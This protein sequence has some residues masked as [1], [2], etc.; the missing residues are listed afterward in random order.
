MA[1]T[2]SELKF[3]LI[4]TGEQAGTWGITTD[5]NIGTAI[6]EAIT[7][8]ADV[9][10]SSAADVTVTLTDTNATQTARNLRLNLTESGAGIGYTGNLV[11]GSGCQIEK[12]YIIN[13]GTTATKTV[14]NTT[15]TGI[16]VP[17]GKTMLV[18]NNGTNVVDVTTYLSSVTLGTDLAVADG[19]TGASTFSSGALLKGAGTSPITTATA[20]TDYVAPAT[21]TTF[22]ATQ[23]FNG[24]TA[25]AAIKTNNIDELAS[26]TA[27]APAS[28]QTFYVNT[29][30]VQ[31]YTNNAAN[32]W[33][34]NFA[35]SSGTSLNTAMATGDSIS[36]TMLTTQSATAYYNSAVQVDGNSVTPKWQGGS[37]PT[38]GNA[39]SIDSYTYV[40]IKTGSAAFTVLA[41][42]TKFA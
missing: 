27:S 41:A 37:A 5:T 20:G 26:I 31:Y 13:N 21:A 18:F 36:V 10:Y 24:S 32:N 1:S 15:G 33:T 34:V 30:A 19:G 23:T 11:L 29:G 14:K 40:I 9:A 35:F 16:A 8:S 3:E 17:A 2:Y 25:T 28:T 4:T 38:S 7:G 6:Q 42:Q 12:L 22:T 39:S